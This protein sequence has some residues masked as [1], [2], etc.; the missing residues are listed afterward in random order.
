[1]VNKRP[2]VT[3]TPGRAK[4]NFKVLCRC[5]TKLTDYVGSLRYVP[6]MGPGNG[7]RAGQEGFKT[8]SFSMCSTKEKTM[9]EK[10]CQSCGIPLEA[11]GRG[12]NADG[13]LSEDYCVHCLKDGAFT[14]DLTMEEMA[15]FC[16]QY[17]ETFNLSNDK[18]FSREAFKYVLLASYPKLK[19]W[20]LPADKLPPC[21]K[22]SIRI[23]ALN[24]LN[25]L[26]IKDM[27]EI[28]ELSLTSGARISREY[29][30]FGHRFRLLDDN[31]SYWHTRVKKI[32]SDGRYYGVTCDHAHILVDESDED[33]NNAKL[34]L[35]KE[36][37]HSF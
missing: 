1:M 24:E 33:G 29:A 37:T 27:P 14:A 20:R 18:L 35:V 30:I 28:T 10:I 36:R 25:A 23:E 9:K 12:T 22:Q 31:A 4:N 32:G 11:D 5:D 34:V 7:I 19:R 16:A 8:V 13:S 6:P 3:P 21:S 17:A 2:T 15:E 26:G